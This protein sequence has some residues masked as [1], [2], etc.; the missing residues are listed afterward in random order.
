V[1][2]NGGRI[3]VESELGRGTC[4][5]VYFPLPREAYAWT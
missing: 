5:S 3:E 1:H 2:K 4:F